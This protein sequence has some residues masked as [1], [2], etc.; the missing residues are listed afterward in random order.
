M[1]KILFIFGSVFSISLESML[2][3]NYSKFLD[4]YNKSFS[5]NGYE[6]YKNNAM[7]IE[8]FNTK[9]NSYEMEINE[10]SD[11]E[12]YG[13]NPIKKSKNK[14]IIE[15]NDI[16][17]PEK[18][19]WRR[20]GVVTEVKNQKNCGSCW[21]FSTTGS[22]EGIIAIKTSN[23]FN[24]S[25]QQLMDCSKSYGN[26]GCQGG[27]MDNAFKYVID[28]GLCLEKDYPYEAETGMCQQC[29]EKGNIQSYG[30]IESD[31]KILKRAV[32]QQPVSVAIQANLSSFRFYSKGVYSD[33]N[34][35]KELDHGV[36]I[37][38]YGYDLMRGK[39]YWLVKNSWG[40]NWGENGYIRIERNIGMC[41][42]DLQASIPLL[43]K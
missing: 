21:A 35:G 18:V 13:S 8:D 34:C 43:K 28:N 15:L 32:A 10:F 33:P 26:N 17:V 9:N 1:F 29:D 3:S 30:D 42:I 5:E 36:L 31:E 22:I 24:F 4:T 41:G 2:M 39:A 37:V 38:G 25:E 12:Y 6:V 7:M 40:E 27:L 16:I 11:I 14:N 19:D 23:L 20:E